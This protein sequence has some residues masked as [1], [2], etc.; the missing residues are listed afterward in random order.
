MTRCLTTGLTERALAAPVARRG[1][2]RAG[3]GRCCAGGQGNGCRCLYLV[4]QPGQ[5]PPGGMP[6]FRGASRSSLSQPSMTGLFLQPAGHPHRSLPRRRQRRRLPHRRPVHM[7]P[8]RQLPYRQLLHTT[9][10]PDRSEQF[11]PRLHPEPLQQVK[12]R[13]RS[14]QPSTGATS[15]PSQG[16][17]RVQVGPNQ[18]ATSEAI[19]PAGWSQIKPSP[20]RRIRLS[21]PM[22]KARYF[23]TD[24]HGGELSRSRIPCQRAVLGPWIATACKPAGPTV[25]AGLPTA[26]EPHPV[27]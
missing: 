11:H 3:S 14:G 20:R 19:R 25:A 9:I 26:P 12:H 27:N 5:H 1:S 21:G 16:A 10:A 17:R 8:I 4:D 18:T 2:R 7:I 6:C 22:G 15:K 23:S 13:H 24:H